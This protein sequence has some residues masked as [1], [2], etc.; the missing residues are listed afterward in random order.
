ME[1]GEGAALVLVGIAPVSG[2][3]WFAQNAFR[4]SEFAKT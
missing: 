2:S 1:V 3:Q 4:K